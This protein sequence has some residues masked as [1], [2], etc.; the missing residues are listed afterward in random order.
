MAR[1]GQS[2]TGGEQA[3]TDSQ[4]A[5]SESGFDLSHFIAILLDRYK[6]ILAIGLAGLILGIATALLSTPLYRASA[7]VQYDPGATDMLEQRST[8]GSQTRARGNNQEG[9]ATQ[10]GLMQS[11]SLAR[12]VA[13]DLNLAS[14]AAFVPQG[15]PVDQRTAAA[16]GVVLGSVTAEPIRGSTLI[17]VNAV[18]TDPA[19]AAKIA[20]A[21]VRGHIASSLRRR[22]EASSY[23]RDF[24][25][26]QLTR[27]KSALEDSERSL[28][29]YAIN[30]GIFRNTTR[31][32]DGREI[33]GSSLAQSDLAKLNDALK[34]AEINRIAAEQR[35]RE[36][37]LNFS[38]EINAGTGPLVQQKSE[39]LAQYDEKLKIYKP[40]YPAMVEL[41]ARIDRLEATINA[42]RKRARS[43]K[44]AELYGEYKSAVRTEAELRVAVAEA[45][46]QVTQDRNRA[47]QYNILQR[48]AD[49]N[50][51]LY[52]ALLQRFKEVGVAGGIGQSDISMVD[53]AKA[54]GGPFSPRP[55]FNALVGLM[56]GLTLGTGLAFA[57]Q[58]LF[59][60]I[61]DPRDVRTKLHLPVLGSI[62]IEV[63]G[64]APV[65]A[66]ADAK[67]VLSEA[68]HSV[69]T[70]LRFSRPEGLPHSLLIT[71]TKPG[72]G[73]STSAYAIAL[74][75]AKLGSKVLL[76]D[77]DL[78]KPTFASSRKDG[79]GLGYLLTSEDELAGYVEKT[80]TANLS[81]LPVGR[82]NGSAAEL[83][84]SNRLPLLVSEAVSRFDMVVI[85]GPPVLGLADAPLLAS[86]V[87]G[88]VLVVESRGSRT[89]EVQ[90]MVRRLSEA[91]AQL[92]GVILTK[93][94]PKRSGYGYGYGYGYFATD[95]EEGETKSV[96]R[97]DL[98]EG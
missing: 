54:P 74:K 24:L 21:T 15:S 76:I 51:T 58:I 93:V 73:K 87:E 53:E 60:T 59:D 9:I 70:A 14:N 18:S 44:R 81:L 34:Q 5:T 94:E 90:E 32:I 62:P 10:I 16:T 79:R 97:I 77:A 12:Q 2:T 64:K 68:Y 78:R 23:A 66:L 88:S 41:R 85:D 96:R 86:V 19:M 22:Y 3:K 17:R 49:T 80:R 48:E 30:A 8:S 95:A 42:E 13:Q 82:L 40:D 84:S 61:V 36:G 98:A 75:V 71:S 72:E 26:E 92:L 11:E 31:G 27:T 38:S 45:K 52:D 63:D 56:A 69:R 91:G 20:N 47:I 29:S 55:L 1:H 65:E 67:S 83:L 25:S 50:R 4:Q 33:E 89:G 35:Y 57:L 7:L 43:D 37:E 28:N 6:L 46:G 39:L